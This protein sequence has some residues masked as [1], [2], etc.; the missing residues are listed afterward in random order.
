MLNSLLTLPSL[1]KVVAIRHSSGC[2]RYLADRVE[3][4]ENELALLREVWSG[5]SVLCGN[6]GD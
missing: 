1:P 4:R 2:C 6:V 3:D 5:D